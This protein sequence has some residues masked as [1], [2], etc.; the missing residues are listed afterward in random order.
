MSGVKNVAKRFKNGEIRYEEAEAAFR[1][2]PGLEEMVISPRK[3]RKKRSK[4]QGG[5]RFE[6]TGRGTDGSATVVDAKFKT[7]SFVSRRYADKLRTSS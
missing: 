4:S 7:E 6:F 2:T 5:T 1:R 3:P